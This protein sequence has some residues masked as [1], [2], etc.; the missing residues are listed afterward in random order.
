VTAHPYGRMIRWYPPEWRERYGPEM[1]ALLEDTYATPGAVP[2]RARMGLLR[3]GLAER[4]RAAGLYGSAPG[5]A[6]QVRAG[7]VLVLCGWALFLVAGAIF[8]KFADNWSV[9]APSTARWVA[10]DSY[11]AV[12]VLAALGCALVALAGLLAVP[13]LA[14]LVRDGRWE[15]V[16]RPVRRAMVSGGVAVVLFGGALAWAHRLSPHDRNGGLAIYSALFVV[17][18]LAAVGAVLCATAAAVSVARRVELPSR[19]LRA[20]GLIALALSGVMALLLAGVALWWSWVAL[21]APDVLLNGTGNSFVYTSDVAPPSLV[22][23]GVLL[24]L[25]LLLAFGGT[26]R[27]ARSWR[28]LD[29]A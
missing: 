16:R 6:E 20:L 1:T 11:D 14:R 10:S 25:G 18:C 19:V 4:A 22:A 5:P 26:R 9:A 3:S 21:H 27:V 12:A 7:S 28:G 13:P 15:S 17:V 2:W 24:M 29:A 8:A 23:A